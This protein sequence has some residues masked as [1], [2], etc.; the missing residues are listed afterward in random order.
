[1]TL[2]TNGLGLIH[3]DGH[4]SH[5]GDVSELSFEN[6]SCALHTGV[7]GAYVANVTCL[8]R[9]YLT[10]SS[11]WECWAILP[12]GYETAA[13]VIE[14]DSDASS[15]R[16]PV[17]VRGSERVRIDVRTTPSGAK[18]VRRSGVRHGGATTDVAIRFIETKGLTRDTLVQNY[19]DGHEGIIVAFRVVSRVATSSIAALFTFYHEHDTGDADVGVVFCGVMSILIT[20]ALIIAIITFPANTPAGPSAPPPTVDYAAVM[21]T[22]VPAAAVPPVEPIAPAPAACVAAAPAPVCTA[23]P[24]AAG[25]AAPAPVETRVLVQYMLDGVPVAAYVDEAAILPASAT[26]IVITPPPKEDGTPRQSVVAINPT[27]WYNDIVY[28]RCNAAGLRRCVSVRPNHKGSFIVAHRSQVHVT[29]E[30]KMD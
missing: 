19:L 27:G 14:V 28:G 16:R 6:V 22:A 26:N 1:M 4:L 10:R 11:D 23:V 17:F 24:A 9:G 12:P 2:G 29:S 21:H 3:L 18:L 30:T 7:D 13:A 5:L 25:V 15:S 8:N 20:I